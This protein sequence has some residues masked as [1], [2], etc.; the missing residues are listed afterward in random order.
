MTDP[1]AIFEPLRPRLFGIAYRML[2]SAADAE[3]LVQETFLRWH[4]AD[5]EAIS[6]PEAWLVTVVTRLA[7]DALR[8]AS[9]QRLEYV[10]EWLPEPIATDPPSQPERSAELASDLSMAF[11]V[12]LERLGPEERAAFL[13]R[14]VFGVSYAEL[15]QVIGKS[16]SATRQAVHRAR[17][18]VRGERAR[19]AVPVET[20]ERLVEAFVAALRAEDR[21]AM[22]RLVAPGV[23]FT[24]DG[25]GRVSAARR[26]VH[27]LERVVRLFL[28]LERKYRRA[29]RHE[30]GWV[31]GEP[32]I[33]TFHGEQLFFTTSLATDG[34][35]IVAFYRVMNPEK[36]GGVMR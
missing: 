9:A 26:V 21:D 12:L 10:G 30:I 29:T 22:L 27:G 18:R 6:S 11:L 31:N 17:L 19:V 33:L 20:T 16:E 32:T 35:K 7:I 13:L 36:L 25:G 14:E 24:S 15:A 23:T 3:D 8:R 1:A 4:A 28:S 34:E 2:G 5:R